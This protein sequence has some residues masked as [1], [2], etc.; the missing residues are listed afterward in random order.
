MTID[1]SDLVPVPGR[2]SIYTIYAHPRDLPDWV[3]VR[4]FDVTVE[5]PSGIVCRAPRIAK[6]GEPVA[7]LFRDL[8][9]ARAYCEQFGLTQMARQPDDDPVIVETWM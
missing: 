9:A 3:V 6:S 8:D 2:T 1:D 5:W 7:G 4:P